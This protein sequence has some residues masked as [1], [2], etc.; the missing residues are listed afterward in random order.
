MYGNSAF[1]QN[2]WLIF[3]L[4][5]MALEMIEANLSLFERNIFQSVDI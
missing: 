4:L 3:L 2:I 5:A 1:L